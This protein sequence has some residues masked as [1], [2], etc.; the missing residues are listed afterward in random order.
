[1]QELIE[2]VGQLSAK[3]RKALAVLLKR[4]GVN[5]FDIAPVFKRTAEEP[6][7]LSYAQQR[8]W[9]LWQWAP[10]SA[11]YNIPTAL[12]LR[13]LL[14]VG[15]LQNS[16]QALTERH[17]TLRTVFTQEA[18]QPLQ[19]VLPAGPFTLEIHP[20]SPEQ[21]IDLEAS[22][23]AF[24]QTQSQKTFDL[25]NGPLLR[26]ALL[27]ITPDDHVL[28]L[29]LHHIVSDDWSLQVMIEELV[30]LYAGFNLGHDAGLPPLPIQYA[31]YALWQ[32]QWM[33]AGEQ[34]RQ[35]AYWQEKLGGE[36][37]VLELPTDRARSVEQSFAGASHN[38]ILDPALSQSLKAF[39]REQNVTLFVLLLASF[40][41]L[42]HRYSGQ[43]DI[44]VGVPV[45]NRGRVEI[46]RL[47]GFFVNTQVFKADVDG[48]ARFVDLL[49]QVKHT[50]QE[51]QAHQDLPF[52]QLVEAL[53]PGRSLSHSPLFQVMFNHTAE[54]RA[55]VETRL[56]GLHIE[57]LEWQS[58]TAQ[59]DLVLNTTEQAHGIEAVLKYATDLFDAA[60]L[61]RLAQDWTLLLQ[62]IAQDPTQR[63]AQLPL[64][65]NA[66]QQQLLAHWNPARIE[67]PVSQCLQQAF[68]AQAERHPDAVAVVFD[69]QRLTYA[70][71]NR[72]ANQYAHR[73]I[74]QGVG[75]EVRVGVAVERSLDMIVAIVAVLKAGGA[76]V[77]LDPSYPDDRLRYMI[78]DSGI[79]LLLTQGHLLAQ[80]PIPQGLACLD[81]SQPLHSGNSV[82]PACQTTPDNL[83]YVIYT[84]GSTG[85]PKGALLPHSNV[86][87][88]FSAT[89]HWFGFGPDD[90]WTL[91]HSYAFDFSVWEIFGALLHGGKLVVVPH[92]VSRSPEEFYRL[93]CDENVTV[94]NQTPSAFKPLMQV[95]CASARH[96]ALRYVV[97]GGEALEV[98][99]LH[100]WFERFGDRA[101]TLINMYGITETTVHV[102]YRPLSMTHLQQSHSSPI[103]EPIVDLSWYL[104]DGAL[105]LVPQGCIGEL[106]IAGA[107]LARG[108]LNQP[109]MTAARF[110]PDPF[111]PQC[112]ERLYR[113]GDLA[114]L[115]GDGV[116][117]YIGRIDHQVKVRGFR[118]ELG[119]IETRLLKHPAVREAV[120]LAVEGLSGQQLA[121]WIVPTEAL[122][123]DAHVA[124]RD[125]IKA[126][127]RET[128]PDYMVPVSWVF[129]ER[130]PLTANGK[131]DRK[132]LPSPDTHQVQEAYAAPRSDLE[133]R[134]AEIWQDVLSVERIGLNDNFFELGGD[135]IISIQVVS[136]ARQ[137]GI[138]FSPKDIFQHQTV[139]RLATVAQQSDAVQ[140][141][142]GD[143]LGAAPL[144]PIQQY[145]FGLD[146][147]QRQHWN[148]SILLTPAEHLD[149][150]L[151]EQ[152]LMHLQRHHDALRLRYRDTDG[153][154]VQEHATV[155]QPPVL[156]RTVTLADSQ[157]LPALC[158][159]LQRSLDLH[160]GPLLQALL[161][162]LPDA[163]QRLLL[164]IHHLVVD[165]V[166]WRI[167]LE[168]LQTAYQQLTTN[169]VL[170]LPA[171]TTAFKDWGEHLQGYARSAA[172][173]AELGYWREQLA[174]ASSDLPL[175]HPQGQLQNRFERSVDTRLDAARTRQ[176][177]QQA[178]AV[179]RT[180]V[181]DLLLTALAQVLCQWTASDSVLVQ[182]EGHG[183]EDVFD[184]L[185]LSRT[186]GW[187]TSMFPVR[188][189]PQASLEASIKGIKEQLRA[190]P[191]KGI[192]YGLLRYLGSADAQAALKDLAQPTV[193]FNYLGQFDNNFDEA[194]LWVPA[195]EDKGAGQDPQA[196]MSNWLT[197][198]GRVYQGQLSLTWTYSGD[199]FEDATINALAHAYEVA[200][201]E[202][203]DH[204]L[205]HPR[206]GL[207]PSDVPLAGLSQAHLDSLP[208]APQQI[209]DLYPLA[210]MQQGILFHS[211]YDADASAYVYQMLL[212]IDGLDV[213]RFQQSW[214]RVVDRH[215]VLRA[216]FIWGR[217]GLDTPL[218]VIHRQ[219]A[220]EM[221]EVDVRDEPDQATALERRARADLERGFDLQN[222]P[223]LRLCLLRTAQDRHRLIF[224]CHHILMDGWSNSLMFGEVLQ[225]YAGHPVPS[226]PGRYR[227]FLAWLQRQDQGAAQTFWRR[228][229][230]ELSEP[231]RLAS[232]CHGQTVPGPGKGVHRLNFDAV[233]TQ[234]LNGFSRQQQ[235]TLN[236][237]VQAAWLLV[238]QRYT[239]QDSVAFGATVSGRPVDLPGIEQQL[240]LFINTLPV[241]ATPQATLSV[242]DWVRSVQDKN[243]LLRDY[244]QTPLQDIQRL[245]QLSGE[246]LFDTLLVFENYPVSQTLEANPGGL[247]FSGLEHR[248]QTN[249]GLTLIAG[250]SD[251]LNLDFNYLTEHFNER[252][253][254][255]LARHLQE[256]LRQFLEAPQ[257]LLGEIGLLPSAE[258][259][260]L[261][262]WN[263]PEAAYP[264]QLLI[265]QGFE[266][267]VQERPHA[268]A[269]SHAGVALSYAEL[270]R[271]A[272]QLARRL[273]A[274]GVGPEVRVGVALP[275]SAELVIALMAVLK[276]GG[277]YVPLDPDYPADRV[278]Y[279]LDDS[280]AKVLLTQQALLAQ[281]PQTQAH[282]VLLEAGVSAVTDLA[283]DNLDVRCASANLAYV[284]YTSGSTGKPKGVAIAHRNV[285]AL[286]HWS[287]EVYS[288]ED[289]Q[290]VL[291]STSVCFDLSV[292]EIFVTLARG[293]S[294]LMAR[295]ALE[296]PD[297]PERDQVRLINTVPSAIAAL[298]RIGQIPQGVRII[299]LAGEPLKQTLVDTLYR[300]TSVQHVYDLY[301]PS[302][303]TTYSTWTRREAGGQANIGRPLVNSTAQLLDAQL[304]AAPLGVA[305][306][307]YLAGEGI[308]RGYLFRPGLTAERFVPDPSSSNGERMYRSGD[309]TRY[310]DDGLIEYV[311]RIDHQ[312]KVRG[313]RIELGEIEVRLLAHDRV[314]EGVV[315]AVEGHSGQ[316]LVAYVVPTQ[317][318]LSLQEQDDLSDSLKAGLNT[319]LPDYMVPAHWLFLDQLPLTP[320]GKLDRKALPTPDTH[321]AQRDYV[322]PRTGL[323]QQIAGVW[324]DILKIDRVGI[325]DNFFTLGGDSIISI[326]VV[327][328]ARQ[329][330]IRFTPKDLFQQ[331]TVQG[332]ATVV[333]VDPLRLTRDQGPVTG[334]TPLLPLQQDYVNAALEQRPPN[335]SA[336]LEPRVQLMPEC[337]E[338]ALQALLAQHDS[339]RLTFK[340]G[341]ARY[342][343]E[344][345][346]GAA[347]LLLQQ[348][349]R[350]IDQLQTLAEQ[351]QHD[352]DLEHGPLLRAVL[353]ELPE[354]EQRLLVVGHWLAVDTV[355]WPLLL[356]DLHHACTQL[357]AGE[358]LVFPAKTA[359]FKRWSE[360]VLDFGHSQKLRAQLP[361]WQAQHAVEAAEW[362]WVPAPI[363]NG[364]EARLSC[365]DQVATPSLLEQACAAYST[366]PREL[367]LTALA[368]VLSR[369]SGQASNVVEL[370]GDGRQALGED[371]DL[372]R[373]VGGFHQHFPVRLTTVEPLGDSIKQIKEQL[374]AVPNQGLGY[375]VLRE[376]IEGAA[377]VGAPRIGF[378]FD[379]VPNRRVESAGDSLWTVAGQS[380]G[381]A[382]SSSRHGLKLEVQL[383]NGQLQFGWS[384]NDQAFKP[385]TLQR[386]ADDFA[387]ELGAVIE[388]CCQPGTRGLTPSDFPLARLDQA[389][390]DALPVA[391][392]TIE[393][394]YPLSPMQEGMLFHTLS[395]NGSSLYVQ[396]VSLPIKG[397]EV[398]RFR[399]A[400]DYVI[401]R[402]AILRTSFH[403][404]D[405][406]AK[407]LQIVH[408]HAALQMQVFDWRELRVSETQ[409]AEFATEDRALGFDLSQ[410]RLQRLTL[411]RLSDEQYQM[412]WTS[413][414]ILMDGWSSS[415]LFGEVLQFYSKGMVSGEN[416]R[417]RDFIAWLHA[418]D[419]DAQEL[420]WKARLAAVTEPT[421][422]SQSI[423]PRHSVDVSGHEAIYSNWN[424]P[425]TA[426]L[427]QFCRDLRITPNTLI[428]G[429]WLLLLQRYTGQR[430][431]TFGATVSGRPESLP[432]VGNMLGLFINT[433]PIIQTPEPD[434]RLADW[435][436][437]VQAYNLDIRD[438]SQAPLADV[439]R[440]SNLGGQALFDSIIVFE[441]FPIDDRL[442]EEN[443]TDLTF[444]KSIGHGVTNV[445]MDLAVML[446]DELSIEYL[447]LRSH[448]S[449]DA[450]ENIRL[451]LEN[452]LEA[453]MSAPYE[454]LGNLQRLSG[455]QWQ[456]MQAW[457]AEPV[458]D[459]QATLLPQLI[460]QHARRQPEAIAL[461]CAGLSLSY[462]ELEQRANRLAHCLIEHGAGPE[463]VIGVALPR[464]LEML[465]SF[466]A[467]LKSGAAYVP[468]D[469]D[470]P[471]ERLAYMIEDSGMAL[472]LSQSSL[473]AT[474]PAPEGLLRLEIDHLDASRYAD[475]APVCRVQEQGLAYLVYTSGSTGRPKGVAVTQGPLSMHCQ[476]IAKLYEMDTRSCEL[477]FMSFAFDGAHE[478]WLSTLYS[479]ARLVIRDGCLWTPEQTYAAL[480]QYGVTIACFPPAY[481]KQL[482]EYAADS[483]IAPPPVRIYC[484]GGD[485]VPDQTFEKVKAALRPEYFTNGYGPTETVVTPMLWK[486]PVSQHCEA[487]YAPIGR[488]VGA[489]S[490]YV[491][492]DD[493]N[494]LPPG[495]CGELYIGGYGIAR[496]YHRRPDLTG[497][498]FVPNPFVAGERLYRSGDLVRLRPD[499]V[500]DY[501]GRI[502]HQVKVRGFRIELG[503]VEA[504]LRQL[505]AVN[506]ALV[507]ARD[508]ASGKQLIGYVVTDGGQDLGDELKAGLRATLPEYMVPAQIV[509]LDAFPVTPNGKLDRKA[510]PEP[511]FKSEEYVAPR[512]QQEQLLAEIWA[513]VLQVEQ[514]G[515]SDNFFEL[516]GDSI[517]SL[518][519][520]SRVRNHPT[521]N[522]DLKLR[523]LM[524]LQTIAGLVEQD[525]AKAGTPPPVKDVTHV[526]SAGLFNLLPI[527]EWFFAEGMAE[528]HHYNQSLLLSARQA[529]D[530]DALEQALGWIEKH[531]DALRLRFCQEGGRWLQRYATP[532]EQREPLLWRREAQTSEHVE[533]LANLTQRSLKLD[534]GPAWR[535]VHIALP[536]GAARLLMVIHHLVVDTVSWRILLD[537]LKVAYEACAMG[538]EPQ[539]PIRTS[540]YRAFA[541]AL[542]TQAPV[543]AE[544]ELG[545]WLQQL[546]QPSVDLLC[547]NP[548]GKNQVRQQAQARLKLSR[549][550]T[551]QLL[552][553]APA[554]YRTQINDLL[555]TALSRA[556]CRWSEQSSA[557][558][559]LEGHGREDLFDSI[560]LSR[561]L[562]WFTSMFPVRLNPDREDIGTSILNVQSQLAAVPQKGIGYG[563]LRHLAG[564]S[565]GRQL[566]D[567]PQARV[568]FNY[569]GQFDQSFD[570]QALLVP[571]LEDSGD[572]Y[573]LKANLG[574]WLEIVGQVYDGQL[575]L[576][577]IYSTQ[578]YRAQTMEGFMQGYQQELEALI[579]HCMAR[580]S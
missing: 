331:Q 21:A 70:E 537:D 80:L 29:T 501:V 457:S 176:L 35:L 123:G 101:P 84:S 519:V 356:Q 251:V 254:V 147:P 33:E 194:A 487:A 377:T 216:G 318:D 65:D 443:D 272:N 332:L 307:L 119:E 198:D 526:A 246:A 376:H 274:L 302:E 326:Q 321:Q 174:E 484:F 535:A 244:E 139:Q 173:E 370:E 36:Q 291:A 138:K 401:E 9:F 158:M 208:I 263:A 347:P 371:L 316:Q 573:S 126:H 69:G 327:S 344:A 44:R 162:D 515:I 452:T 352:L 52:E 252:S 190:I 506:D 489:R 399:A 340:D 411:L 77:P 245:A 556:L 523:D 258:Q 203:I 336:L 2:S 68:E 3:Q 270:N 178:P 574:N 538:L 338:H 227:D 464:S 74:A 418:Q 482:A 343:D 132:Q 19:V 531:H 82:N 94:L 545:Y 253:I 160:N 407:P 447:Y 566:A 511:T 497:E 568:T 534:D 471:P 378:S 116:I 473:R 249:Y 95:A 4:K 504:R 562:G 157:T 241:I 437:Q 335:R 199:V 151:L 467:V 236:S 290:G 14:D 128:L 250:A 210:P 200:L 351:A 565:L 49:R 558:I 232:A 463:V 106:Y 439:Q 282:V 448:F 226:S 153:G 339:L 242:R 66:R 536:D 11:A 222:P 494:P 280:Q 28:V 297:L 110:V 197:I 459:H 81:L 189:K 398:E 10:H 211:L 27:Q 541:E 182:L 298:Q 529:L 271:R 185:D 450:V 288:E 492:D 362:C 317:T 54:R 578:R 201:G 412:I 113:T 366:E 284:I 403:W 269:L 552:K 187:F 235:V 469:I 67:H 273:V 559:L 238:L 483:G 286:I 121:T 23:Q 156:L 525:V 234:R 353:F 88:L 192:G 532:T 212:D 76:Y 118:I 172:L 98:Q 478:R 355:A 219:L 453:M 421:A 445:P 461:Q 61:E 466:L 131:L 78:E 42:L 228:Q 547:D 490:L 446:G 18:E 423:H 195:T 243:L 509:C 20:L 114:R 83:A 30:Q 561:S 186:V 349:V 518:Q 394:I 361:F 386:L 359:S 431:V 479:G 305:A 563:V 311:G 152:S 320:N 539:L 248:E 267:Q 184:D 91:F 233:F 34:A 17:E 308:T 224:T 129:L 500:L 6:L 551:D 294:I 372:T 460:S 527:Q 277:A 206:G 239:G 486:V 96:N 310:R 422:L 465:V 214:Q 405:G 474:L 530:L 86:M 223:L 293:G 247:R 444:G 428:Q 146:I 475:E 542:Q 485:A 516:G 51:A 276:A 470:Y 16:L 395:D 289:L 136:R 149:R 337:V 103:G 505:E 329:L 304:H 348:R 388:H 188:L 408:V 334:S 100:P 342:R 346:P 115:R 400:W 135:S 79:A 205:S 154:W 22:I 416:G 324:Q 301:G 495:F 32:R 7:L 328:R 391:A 550:H 313:L 133:Q 240:G 363:L 256:V 433:L 166:S 285:Q 575:A 159:E 207:T 442:Q 62:G 491:L 260:S 549:E 374:R 141:M 71:L 357:M 402:Q 171:K 368:R 385:S 38:L 496:G 449:A 498:R 122:V 259:H 546:D 112:G 413:H 124:V 279:M 528:P 345:P 554:V 125:A 120:V 458:A 209:E 92:D 383:L 99:S 53:E 127:L 5:L 454:R 436:N 24:V 275:R 93:L 45:A 468:L 202:L 440:W 164:V 548:R 410:A 218:Q 170:R 75:P 397:L 513:Q 381:T 503:E 389:Q 354:G 295:N 333:S 193:T 41:V 85:Q 89:D 72:R 43:A 451:T 48:Q 56:N 262:Q 111:N 90:S 196:P 177:L 278:A 512:T 148:Q 426:R 571:A 567:L 281:W 462:G 579:E 37:P 102:T 55:S 364:A 268:M 107:G 330:G 430:T 409:I 296:L 521:L 387:E 323:E 105:N 13:G 360:Q 375:G 341:L 358:A 438:Y 384:S 520:I 213:A 424:V 303:D 390:L 144:T 183:R 143:V 502:D 576:R 455:E 47:I 432:N 231:T 31:D 104:L 237:L 287:R 524:R 404:Q 488:A 373:T 367:L 480:H 169:R 369:W 266:A 87:R 540:S 476:A 309:L 225:D 283:A 63:I 553:Q 414:H 215:E 46:E 1:M 168:D 434:Q 165:G 60:T 292:W 134:L 73:L 417:Y 299:N 396:Q 179:Y 314:R 108:Y 58:Q 181:N 137:A 564:T 221:P 382:V 145:F 57:P 50:A 117:E 315:L 180:Q 163:S 429:A 499:G 167:L 319:H 456:A 420:F 379:E 229:L 39:A 175:D 26:A 257:R 425:Q 264:T 312:V 191:H 544:Q 161:V 109:G 59:F 300:D 415:R 40:Q 510:L 220:L 508:N 435:L 204:C 97:F 380:P 155:D 441:N 325:T 577:C 419:Q 493:L 365:L 15:A 560:D 514:V 507:I 477:H 555:L 517:L 322:A 570:E 261:A 393:D 392:A 557:L 572:N 265:H 140:A 472:L 522:M 255:G 350:D 130:L 427:L 142:Q 580:I 481:L 543:I 406:L 12:R 150:G 533:A 306:E 25:Q 8:Q 230:A 217:D 569:L 64:L